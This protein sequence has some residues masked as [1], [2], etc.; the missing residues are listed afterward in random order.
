MNF[1]NMSK[2]LALNQ[3]R[4]QITH[5]RTLIDLAGVAQMGCPYGAI[6]SLCG[7]CSRY[8]LIAS[9]APNFDLIN[10]EKG[11]SRKRVGPR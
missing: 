7:Q 2:C 10:A 5:K 9:T 1:V 6:L 3:A 8:H 4:S 11:F